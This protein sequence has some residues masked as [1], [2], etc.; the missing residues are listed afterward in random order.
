MAFTDVEKIRIEV[1]VP[2]EILDDSTI[3]YFLEKN[4]GSIRRTSLDVARATLFQLSQWVRFKAAELES[5]DNQYFQQYMAAL[6]L[7]LSDPNYSI[8]LSGAS[9][10][11]GGIS[12]SDMRANLENTDVN[13]V[14]VENSAPTGYYSYSEKSP[15]TV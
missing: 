9:P 3:E 8:A 12:L 14:K 4:N 15:F 7:Y 2:A 6:K 5:Y 11:C 1:A 10:Y 13:P